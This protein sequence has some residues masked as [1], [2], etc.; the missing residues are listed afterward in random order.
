MEILATLDLP[1]ICLYH[2]HDINS[3]VHSVLNSSNPTLV[4][5]R[6]LLR[7]SS[8]PSNLSSSSF[9]LH[10]LPPTQLIRYSFLTPPYSKQILS[11]LNKFVFQYSDITNEKHP[12]ICHSLVK[13]QSC[14]ATHR[15][16]VGQISTPFRIRLISN[17]KL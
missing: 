12:K 6:P 3:L 10:N 5:P 9:E 1:L 15:N 7:S 16:D 2:V 4:D 14:Y 8:F 17:T 13:Y 11:I